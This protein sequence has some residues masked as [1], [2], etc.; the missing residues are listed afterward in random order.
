M[1]NMLDEMERNPSIAAVLK[2]PY[3][4]N[5]AGDRRGLDGPERVLPEYDADFG[6]WVTPFV[7]GMINTKVVRR[8]NAVMGYP[9][10]EDFRYDE[11]TLMPFGPAGFPIAAAVSAGSATFTAAASVGTFRRLLTRMLPK[12]GAGP[13]RAAQEAG[14]FVIELLGRHPSDSTLNLR[15]Q[16]RG[17]RDPGYGS[18]SKMLGESAVCLA[19]DALDSPGGVLTPASAMG[20][21][22]LARLNDNAGVTFELV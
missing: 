4:L 14:Y 12:P 19:Q 20:S 22:L 16:I 2:D 5:P 1:L 7:M 18:T 13:S 17:D 8:S 15:A 3:G 11:G 9:Y 10:G 6:A 21:A